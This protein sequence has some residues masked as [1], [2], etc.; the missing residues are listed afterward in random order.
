MAGIRPLP[1]AAE[2][3]TIGRSTAALN[4]AGIRREEVAAQATIPDGYL[5]ASFPTA[6]DIMVPPTE[7]TN[8]I[9][10]YRNRD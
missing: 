4:R 1:K 9:A 10:E 5:T 3:I 2:C 8:L 6:A 7:P